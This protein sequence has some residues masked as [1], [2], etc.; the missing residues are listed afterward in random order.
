MDARARVLLKA[1]AILRGRRLEACALMTLEVG[2]NYAEADVEVAEAI[3]FLEY[4]A[5]EAMKYEG[6]GAA[7][8]TW[9]D[10]EENGLM[11]LPLGVG[12]SISP[13]NFPLRH[14]S[15]HA[16]RAHRGGK[17]HDRQAR[18]GQRHDRGPDGRDSDGGRAARRSGSVSARRGRGG[19]RVPDHARPHPLHHVYRQPQRRPAHQRGGG[20]APD[21]ARSSSSA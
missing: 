1:A 13:W 17:L 6:F 7:E 5:R 16:G 11:Y 3:D 8:T 12:V 21:R 10:G 18:R 14:L 19:R 2:K 15:G 20:E 4:Y 9:Y